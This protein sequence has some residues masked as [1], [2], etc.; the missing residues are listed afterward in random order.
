MRAALLLLSLLLALS[1]QQ[2]LYLLDCGPH[3]SASV[4]SIRQEGYTG[5][6]YVIETSTQEPSECRLKAAP[7]DALETAHYR[8]LSHTSA[9]N[10]TLCLPW[11][12]YWDG[13]AY[14]LL[15]ILAMGASAYAAA[16]NDASPSCWWPARQAGVYAVVATDSNGEPQS[17]SNTCTD[18]ADAERVLYI[19]ACSTSEATAIAAA[20]SLTE[21]LTRSVSC[22]DLLRA[23]QWPFM[24]AMLAGFG[25]VATI[26]LLLL[27]YRA[28]F[29]VPPSITTEA[30]Q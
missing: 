8:V 23:W 21:N 12:E 30:I 9:P 13:T 26:A 19:S 14:S 2:E 27:V 3:E 29:Y 20:R 10:T 7:L 5:T 1:Y 4:D 24:Y 17:F 16:G 28:F 15:D 6:L 25:V 22:P 18:K 11:G